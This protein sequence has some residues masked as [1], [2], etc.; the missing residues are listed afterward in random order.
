MAYPSYHGNKK[1]TPSLG[2]AGQTASVTSP[3]NYDSQV[4]V[5]K[6]RAD[7]WE[8]V[9]FSDLNDLVSQ[10]ESGNGGQVYVGEWQMC[11]LSYR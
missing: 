3:V 8:T 9:E 7:S 2:P 10:H 1:A 6:S 11:T 5:S 4:G